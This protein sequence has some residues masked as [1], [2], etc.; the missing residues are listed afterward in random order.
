VVSTKNFTNLENIENQRVHFFSKFNTFAPGIDNYFPVNIDYSP[1]QE[2]AKS[3]SHTSA[4]IQGSEEEG[5][6]LAV[7]EELVSQSVHLT[8]AGGPG[9]PMVSPRK[10]T[11]YSLPS[12]RSNAVSPSYHYPILEPDALVAGHRAPSRPSS[13]SSS[14]DVVKPVSNKNLSAKLRSRSVGVVENFS[15]SGALQEMGSFSSSSS[16]KQRVSRK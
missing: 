11:K 13:P 12:S 15:E 9:F 10:G 4:E 1:V 14:E 6:E 3:M 5:P 16:V 8:S 7:H 2:T